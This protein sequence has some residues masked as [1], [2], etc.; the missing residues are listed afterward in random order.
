MLI[1]SLKGFQIVHR[2]KKRGKTKVGLA[3]KLSIFK[4]KLLRIYYLGCARESGL[5]SYRLL[6]ICGFCSKGFPLALGAYVGYDI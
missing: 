3:V 5:F 4:C 6:I 1:I 2:F